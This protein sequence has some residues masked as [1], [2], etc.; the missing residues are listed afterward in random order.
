MICS[1]EPHLITVFSDNILLSISLNGRLNYKLLLHPRVFVEA[2][3]MS[4]KINL[5]SGLLGHIES[6]I[7]PRYARGVFKTQ[8][9]FETLG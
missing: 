8:K 9:T 2:N 7:P 1:V 6:Q 3:K 4:D 5:T